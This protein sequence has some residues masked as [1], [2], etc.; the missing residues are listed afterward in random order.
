M[1]PIGKYVGTALGLSAYLKSFTTTQ[2]WT[3]TSIR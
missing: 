2:L 1:K 3:K